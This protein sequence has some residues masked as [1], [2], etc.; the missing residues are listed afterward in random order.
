MYW[1]IREN[2]GTHSTSACWKLRAQ[3]NRRSSAAVVET[4]ALTK[5]YI[6]CSQ[7]CSITY[8]V[9]R[10][11]VQEQFLAMYDMEG[12][13]HFYTTTPSLR[14]DLATESPRSLFS[15]FSKKEPSETVERLRE[16]LDC[17]GAGFSFNTSLCT[18]GTSQKM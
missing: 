10:V 5:Q 1:Y 17:F 4:R 7:E 11:L 16:L 13:A 15:A 12:S 8:L 6:Q 3:Q 2:E 18:F 9:G 14:R